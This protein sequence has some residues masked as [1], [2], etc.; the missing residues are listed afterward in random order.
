M[1]AR[2]ARRAC[3]TRL[4][5][6]ASSSS[7][8]GSTLPL[9]S[10][11]HLDGGARLVRQLV[12]D[13]LRLPAEAPV[14]AAST[15]STSR[16]E[17]SSTTVSRCASPSGETMSTISVSPSC[18][19]RPSAGTSSATDSRS[20]SALPRDELLRH[21]AVG[22]AHFELAPV[23]DLDLGLDG[24]GRPEAPGRGVVGRKLELVLRLRDRADPREAAAF[25][26]QPE[27][28]VDRLGVDPLLAE[29]LHE[30][31]PR[32]L[33]GP[34]PDLDEAARS[35]WRSTGVVDVVPRHIDRQHG[36]AAELLDLRLHPVIQA[37]VDRDESSCRASSATRRSIS[38]RS[39]RTRSSGWPA[40]SSSSQSTYVVPGSMGRRRRSPS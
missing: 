32:H 8:S 7:S 39:S 3:R 6:L 25:Q 1:S 37:G 20:A 16:P 15:S 5:D 40:G 11:T 22:P 38:S 17:P 29:T 13:A 34:K 30:H 10:L 28:A 33:A 26:N 12:G 14:N 23:D 24:H 35:R 4:R 21:L 31:R 9:I 36:V 27:M 19:A 18:A 2:G